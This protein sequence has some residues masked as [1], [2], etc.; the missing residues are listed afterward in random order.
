[1]TKKN[2]NAAGTSSKDVEVYLSV[3][4]RMGE[5]WNRSRE[6]FTKYVEK[7]P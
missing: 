3:L 4:A 1:M 6:C 7:N 5:R 2:K